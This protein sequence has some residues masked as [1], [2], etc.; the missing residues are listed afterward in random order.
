MAIEDQIAVQMADL[1]LVT[2]ADDSGRDLYTI[3]TIA[4]LPQTS[5]GRA[6]VSIYKEKHNYI[7]SY[8]PA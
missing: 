2:R 4:R 6:V 7:S 8:S 1:S 3:Y 5:I